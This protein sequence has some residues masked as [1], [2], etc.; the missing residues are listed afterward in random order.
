MAGTRTTAVSRVPER[1]LRDQVARGGRSAAAADIRGISAVMI[2]TATM[3]WAIMKIR[4][5]LLKIERA[6]RVRAAV[7]R[8]LGQLE[9]HDHGAIWLTTT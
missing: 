5:A 4:N 8:Q 6:G 7:G 1:E 9:Q 3:P 2:E